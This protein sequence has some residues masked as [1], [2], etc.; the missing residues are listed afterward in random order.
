LRCTIIQGRS[1]R[2]VPAR[3]E[4]R[5]SV[6]GS[7]LALVHRDLIITLAAWHKLPAVYVSRYFVAGGLRTRLVASVSYDE[8][9]SKRLRFN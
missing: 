2:G 1:R 3:I 6:T 8:T 9:V 5:P 4:W 7:A